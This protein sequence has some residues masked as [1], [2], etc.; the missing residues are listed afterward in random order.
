[1]T[2]SLL[3]ARG[4]RAEGAVM[5]KRTAAIVLGMTL[6]TWI[7]GCGK[8]DETAKLLDPSRPVTITVWHYY[9]GTQQAA[10]DQLVEKFNETR[11]KELG[12]YVEEYSQG[13]VEE[14]EAAVMA[15]LNREVG[16][17]DMPDIFSAYADTA[18]AINRQ[19][20]L[21]DISC[22]LTQEDEEPYVQSFLEE[23]R[24]GEKGELIIFPTAKSS[25][26]FMLNTTDWEPFAEATGADI[27]DLSTME[28]VAAC[29]Q[30]YYEWTDALTP[31]VPGDGRAFYG[32]DA[33]ANL[34]VIGVR[35]MG[36]ELVEVHPG[37]APVLHADKEMMRRI[38]DCF[39]V[40]YVKGYFGAFGR[41]RSDDVKTGELLAYTGSSASALYFPKQVEKEDGTSYPIEYTVL[42]APVFEGG[43]PYA[44][45]QGAGMVVS[46]S[47]QTKEYASVTFLKWFTEEEN[48]LEFSVNSGY[49]PVKKNACTK[50]KLDGMIERNGIQ[51][52]ARAYDTMLVAFDTIGAEKLYT[53]KAFE[54][55]MEIRKVLEY[56]LV[57]IA[58]AGREKVSGLVKSGMPL[59][60]A[61]K[62]YISDEAFDSWY[63]GFR[64]AI[65]PQGADGPGRDDSIVD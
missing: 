3:D 65:L 58:A 41:F 39:Y 49:L 2:P 4:K 35:Q 23:G 57:D 31:D 13:N 25:E 45:Q 42:P 14:L 54:N 61:A 36:K 32:R 44:V 19:G 30:S 62:P 37:E 64:A 52:D 21:A 29:A 43:E 1:M 55:G 46:K 12:I 28:G 16:S 34:F 15:S 27:K 17:G 38:W 10:F 24:I 20:A 9:N 6:L 5:R 33:V 7:A 11:G 47:T 8:A 63:D 50:E 40:P 56:N 59:E 60:E 18:Y 51:M 26:I 22:W 48:N 53:N